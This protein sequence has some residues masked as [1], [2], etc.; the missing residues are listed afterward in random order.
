MDLNRAGVP[1][2]EIVTEPDLHSAEEVR[3]Y[4]TALRTLLRYLGVNSGDMQK[5]VMRIE[6]NISVRPA[7]SPELG[8]RTEIKNLNSF[9]ALERSVAY[10]IQRQIEL[11]RQGQPVVAGD[12]RLGRSP[13]RHLHPAQSRKTEDDY[14]YFPE[15]DLPPLVLEPAWVEQVRA[16]RCPSCPR[17]ACTAS[18][19][20]YGLSAYDA[21]VLIAERAVADYFRSRRRSASGASPKVGRQLDHRRAVRPAQPGRRGHRSLPGRA[22]G[23]GGL[24]PDGQPGRDQPEHRQS[25][26]GGDVPERQDRRGDHRRERGLR[27]ISDAGLDRRA[28]PAGAGREPG[29]GR[30]LPERAKRAWRTGSSAR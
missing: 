14:R 15:P 21:G 11:L 6:P 2:L 17:P 9:R 7:G 13:R 28:G 3:A 5:G 16:R 1:L 25:R 4:A 20:Q 10:E 8:T 23:P 27:Q 26:A 19:Q 24:A 30:Q 22:A 12:P 29:A 18:R